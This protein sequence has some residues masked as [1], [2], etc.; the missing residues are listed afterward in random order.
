MSL[1]HSEITFPKF[2]NYNFLYF[3][4]LLIEPQ[5]PTEEIGKI[6]YKPENK[7]LQ[8]LTVPKTS[9]LRSVAA[10]VLL[11]LHHKIKVHTHAEQ[12]LKVFAGLL[13]DALDGAAALAD[14]DTLLGIAFHVDACQDA[15]EVL[16]L[17]VF[18][19]LD[20]DSDGMRNLVAKRS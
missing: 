4:E 16:L 17:L 11:D 12:L 5:L 8:T 10:P 13:A 15:V 20:G 1:K 9:D 7:L 19:V 3:S 6:S 2:I 14:D 18:H